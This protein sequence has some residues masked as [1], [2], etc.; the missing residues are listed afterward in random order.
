MAV[1][2][3]SSVTLAWL[4]PDEQDGEVDALGELLL[5]TSAI[6]PAIWPY[7]VGNALL[8]ARRRVRVT[9][10]D[11]SRFR[12]ALGMLA[13]EVDPV[14]AGVVLGA[15]AELADRHDL[16]TYDAAY[17]ELAMRRALPLATLDQRL[18]KVCASLRVK[19]LPR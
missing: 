18:R 7:E 13:I 12:R 8:V 10:A 16:T 4:L 19:S 6:V 3:D 14:A 15:V 5:T 2:L 9:H 1:V 11:I 17:V